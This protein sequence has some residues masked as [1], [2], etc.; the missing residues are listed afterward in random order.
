MKIFVLE[1]ICRFVTTEARRST[2]NHGGLLLTQEVYIL[3]KHS[4]THQFNNSSIPFCG[5][6]FSYIL[7]TLFTTVTIVVAS[8]APEK[9]SMMSFCASQT[10][11]C[12]PR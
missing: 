7:K 4:S 12:V 10:S 1:G 5:Y 2:E 6:Y 11:P 8:M 3:P 9:A